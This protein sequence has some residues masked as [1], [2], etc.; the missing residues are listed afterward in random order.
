MKKLFFIIVA[1]FI[2][3]NSPLFANEDYNYDDYDY[4]Y[5][6]Y[7]TSYDTDSKTFPI[8]IALFNPIQIVNKN[9][10]I[11]GL[12]LNFIYGVNKNV[13]G[14]DLG[15][16]NKATGNV[17]AVQYGLI[18]LVSGNF[19]GL[20]S[21]AV[22]IVDGDFTGLQGSILTNITK[23]SLTGVQASWGFNYAGKVKGLQ[24]SI[25]G[26]YTKDLNGVQIGLFN[27]NGNKK[28]LGFFPLINV[29]F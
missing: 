4:S 11:Y 21:G 20:Q 15:L 27:I 13:T 2:L 7:D 17:C 25:L 29:S 26:N 9:N 19:K 10:S 23:S 1:L 16:I 3:G 5:D 6:S 8:Q 12:R 28:P 24:I 14:L 22:N 18:N